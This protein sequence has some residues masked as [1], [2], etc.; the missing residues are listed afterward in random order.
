[1]VIRARRSGSDTLVSDDSSSGKGRISL[2]VD[3]DADS[4][5]PDVPV[6]LAS[7]DLIM[8]LFPRSTWESVQ[9]LTD[10]FGGGSVGETIGYALKLLEQSL[11]KQK[12]E[13]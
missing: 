6:G 4:T 5:I 13:G 8:V 12:G 2:S 7:D 1:M 10:E 3:L 9:K 11:R